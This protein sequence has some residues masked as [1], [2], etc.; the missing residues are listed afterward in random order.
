MPQTRNVSSLTKKS[1]IT[2]TKEIR[3][4]LGVKPG[5]RVGFKI[6][7]SEV[8]IVP[9]PSLLD[10]SFGKVKPKKSPEDFKKQRNYVMRKIA[11]EVV[12]EY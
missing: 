4:F 5:D 7:G 9:Q 12:K 10:K 11:K 6:E 1:Q 2:L 8:K 3:N